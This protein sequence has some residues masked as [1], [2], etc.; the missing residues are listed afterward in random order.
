MKK[1]ILN[2]EQKHIWAIEKAYWDALKSENIAKF[3][4]FYHKDFIGWSD[5]PKPANKDG[6]RDSSL[7]MVKKMGMKLCVYN[8]NLFAIQFIENVAVVHYSSNSVWKNE[9]GES[10]GIDKW[11]KITHIWMKAEDGYQ[12]IGGAAAPLQVS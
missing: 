4:N 6:V 2:D 8:L 1:N 5:A 9:N 7:Y 11:T 12:I 10:I 3:L